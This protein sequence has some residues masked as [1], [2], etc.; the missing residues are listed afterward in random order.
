MINCNIYQFSWKNGRLTPFGI[1]WS[2]TIAMYSSLLEIRSLWAHFRHSGISYFE[3]ISGGALRLRHFRI[4]ADQLKTFRRGM[5]VYCFSKK[6]KLK[7]LLNPITCLCIIPIFIDE[8]RYDWKINWKLLSVTNRNKLPV[9]AK[10]S[11][12]HQPTAC[13]TVSRQSVDSTMIKHK[14]PISGAFLRI[15]L[16]RARFRES[17]LSNVC[18]ACCLATTVAYYKLSAWCVLARN[19]SARNLQ[20]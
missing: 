18:A 11:R 10:S 7:V 5:K 4:S 16:D 17:A 3:Q 9:K 12:I 15:Y 13:N 8:A 2:C 19:S 1:R 20:N 14:V 6:C